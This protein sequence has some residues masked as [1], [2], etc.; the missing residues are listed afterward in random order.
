MDAHALYTATDDGKP[1]LSIMDL[2]TRQ[3]QALR[4]VGSAVAYRHEEAIKK[5]E[6]KRG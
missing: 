4:V 6:A 3:A 1:G 2:T 5:A